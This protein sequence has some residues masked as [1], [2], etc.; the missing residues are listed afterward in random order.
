MKICY[1]IA[2]MTKERDFSQLPTAAGFAEP[3]IAAEPIS[4]DRAAE[5]GADTLA[6]LFDQRFLDTQGLPRGA[7]LD[8]LT[9][10][11]EGLDLSQGVPTLCINL[12]DSSRWVTPGQLVAARQDFDRRRG[13]PETFVWPGMYSQRNAAWWNKRVVGNVQP[14]TPE[15]FGAVDLGNTGQVKTWGQQQA[16]IT[17]SGLPAMSVGDWLMLDTLAIVSDGE[18]PRPDRADEDTITRFPQHERDV[19]DALGVVFGPFAYVD[20]DARARL[21]ESDGSARPGLGFRLLMGPDN[22]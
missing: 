7:I 3:V 16:A 5:L 6:A 17:N 12:V 11:F 15:F 9:G 4:T 8:T 14:S 2:T 18:I 19:S 13:L 22:A 10:H 1:K 20:G 21:S